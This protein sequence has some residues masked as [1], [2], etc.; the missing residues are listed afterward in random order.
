MNLKFV[1]NILEMELLE[2]FLQ[3]TIHTPLIPRVG[4][5]RITSA[6]LLR[7]ATSLHL[8]SSPLQPRLGT[9]QQQQQQQHKQRVLGGIIRCLCLLR[10]QINTMLK[11]KLNQCLCCKRTVKVFKKNIGSTQPLLNDVM[12][13]PG[14]SDLYPAPVSPLAVSSALLCG[15]N[16]AT[17][18]A[19]H[20]SGVGRAPVAS[21]AGNEPSQSLFHN[22]RE[23]G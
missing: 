2:S 15:L 14:P 21:R 8:P 16:P 10:I 6:P 22:H 20:C 9:Q 23:I 11:L 18:L 19:L 5:Y 12:S 13:A 17:T 4:V 7:W 3:S 1:Y